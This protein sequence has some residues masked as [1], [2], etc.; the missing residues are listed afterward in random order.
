MTDQCNT[1][2][3]LRFEIEKVIGESFQIDPVKPAADHVKAVPIVGRGVHKFSEFIQKV[4]AKPVR[5]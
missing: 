3:G 1:N 2:S 5:F 4:I